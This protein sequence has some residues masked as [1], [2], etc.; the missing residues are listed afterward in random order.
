M[1]EKLLKAY[2]K[3]LFIKYTE[4]HGASLH[5][6]KEKKFCIGDAVLCYEVPGMVEVSNTGEILKGPAVDVVSELKHRGWI[7]TD[8][9]RFW[10]TESGVKEAEITQLRRVFNYLNANPWIATSIALA[11]LFI[12]ITSL[13]VSNN[14]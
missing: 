10:L 2:L 1:D 4:E 6:L 8:S 3:H 7:E 14:A 5:K 13:I 12:S 9:L 11:S